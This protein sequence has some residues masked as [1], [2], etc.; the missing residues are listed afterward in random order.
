MLRGRRGL[1]SGIVAIVTDMASVEVAAVRETSAG[2][3]EEELLAAEVGTLCQT[4]QIAHIGCKPHK[5]S[6]TMR[7]A[8]DNS[9]LMEK[10]LLGRRATH[11]VN[12]HYKVEK[13]YTELRED[14]THFEQKPSGKR[15]KVPRLADYS[16]TGFAGCFSARL[17]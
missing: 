1:M 12:N 16:D 11:F 9:G 4:L 5:L 2:L 13:V 14:E 15:G 10:C 7:K 8:V 6:T 3:S 17:G